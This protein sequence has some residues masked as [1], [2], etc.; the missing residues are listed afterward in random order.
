[1]TGNQTCDLLAYRMTLAEPHRP[2]LKQLSLD[3]KRDT[4]SDALIG[5]FNIP[6]TPVGRSY[7]QNQQENSSLK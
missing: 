2:G 3:V 1:M 6:L 7:R 5:D 4:D